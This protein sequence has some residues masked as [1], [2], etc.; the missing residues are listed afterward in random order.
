MPVLKVTGSDNKEK[1]SYKI[2]MIF[3]TCPCKLVI[4]SSY[5]NYMETPNRDCKE[6]SFQDFY[7]SCNS[8]AVLVIIR[9][10]GSVS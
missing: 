9:F 8:G 7:N 3:H 10:F 1:D 5:V 4:G 2:A 6:I